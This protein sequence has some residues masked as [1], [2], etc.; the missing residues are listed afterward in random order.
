MHLLETESWSLGFFQS[1]STLLSC[2]V[3]YLFVNA[4][5]MMEKGK[6]I[7][8]FRNLFFVRCWDIEEMI[9]LHFIWYGTRR[10]GGGQ[11]VEKV[12][13][14]VEIF[15]W[16]FRFKDLF[17][18]LRCQDLTQHM[19]LTLFCFIIGFAQGYQL[20]EPSRCQGYCSRCC[21]HSSQQQPWSSWSP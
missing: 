14:S 21:F 3:L 10:I 2:L 20:W 8:V 12:R 1:V 4:G 13:V 16:P 9:R 7:F 6:R 19:N 15:R 5:F 11:H 18:S 17:C